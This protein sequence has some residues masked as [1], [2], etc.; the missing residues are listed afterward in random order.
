MTVPGNAF[1]VGPPEEP[2]RYRLLRSVGGGGEAALWQAAVRLA[3]AEEH[4]AVKI[5]GEQHRD[6]ATWRDRWVEQ[7][8]LLRLVRHP[9]VVG[10]HCAFEGAR[11]HRPGEATA[12]V[13]TLYLVMNWVDGQDLRD[14]LPAHAGPA[15][16][17]AAFRLLAQ[18]AD[19]L[20]WLHSGRATPSGRPVIHGDI[21]PANVVVNAE[22]Q[23]VLVDFGLF[24]LVRHVTVVPM[25]TPGFV[26]PEVARGEY[27]P[28]TDRYAFG[29]LAYYLLVGEH[30]TDPARLRT[31]LA[32]VV[33]PSGP[34]SL[35][36]AMAIFD[37][38]PARRPPLSGWLRS[39]RTVSST[40]SLTDRL[41]PL[42][43]AAA[44]GAPGQLPARGQRPGPVRPTVHAG[45]ASIVPSAAGRGWMW[46]GLGAAAAAFLSVLLLVMFI[47]TRTNTPTGA[48]DAAGTQ[49]GNAS[50]TTG[51]AGARS[52]S[53]RSSLDAPAAAY[54]GTV[55]LTSLSGSRAADNASVGTATLQDKR[56]T[57]SIVPRDS[58]WCRWVS[59][60]NLNR[61]YRQLDMIAGI[62]DTSALG[63]TATLWIRLDDAPAQTIGLELGKSVPLTLDVRNSFRIQLTMTAPSNG[64]C[65]DLLPVVAVPRLTPA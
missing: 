47:V 58:Y 14:W 23:A 21:S 42:A 43:P 52:P 38:D 49:T 62:D 63:S 61:K 28:A 4:V 27:S 17:P 55:W 29:A 1:Y 12:E 46:A 34:G 51:A 40:I 57:P 11:M 16:R 13:E 44:T 53:A 35:D 60:Y 18:I 25:G 48:A 65:R 15:E 3:G 31:G 39:L 2:D 64:N 10:V 8:D 32:T 45:P 20:D 37:P 54:P 9:G 33:P 7:V 56:Y 6:R 41:P 19:V 26:A 5:L 36:A 50:R 30:P 22:G 24:R 59:D